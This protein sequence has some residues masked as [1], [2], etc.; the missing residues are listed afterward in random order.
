MI[1]FLGN[2]MVAF[3]VVQLHHAYMYCETEVEPMLL[4]GSSQ[5]EHAD[6]DN[7]GYI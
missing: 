1:I 4:F 7:D 2:P 3:M 5:I 6:D